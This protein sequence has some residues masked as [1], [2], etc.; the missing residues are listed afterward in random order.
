[1]RPFNTVYRVIRTADGV[2]LSRITSPSEAEQILPSNVARIC[3]VV[4]E[5]DYGNHTPGTYQLALSIL[6]DFTGHPELALERYEALVDHTLVHWGWPAFNLS[7]ADIMQFLLAT[8]RPEETE[9][10][11]MEGGER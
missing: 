1:M 11:A 3:Q 8:E 6:L 7:G 10:A 5:F 2:C 9:A 4:H